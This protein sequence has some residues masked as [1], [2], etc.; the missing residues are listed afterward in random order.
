MRTSNAKEDTRI[1][2]GF[3]IG[4][5]FLVRSGRFAAIFNFRRWQIRHLQMVPKSV[6]ALDFKLAYFH[7]LRKGFTP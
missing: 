6:F 5:G 3:K 1:K 4:H 7:G 2:G